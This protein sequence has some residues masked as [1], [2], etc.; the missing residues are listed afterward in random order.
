ML[1]IGAIENV[2]FEI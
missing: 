1:L 2:R